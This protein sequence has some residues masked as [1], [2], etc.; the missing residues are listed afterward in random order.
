[1]KTSSPYF[2]VKDSTGTDQLPL[3]ATSAEVNISGVI[4][5]VRVK[6]TYCNEGTSV[7]EAIYVFPASTRAAVNYMQMTL[8]NRILIARIEE[9]QKARQEYEEAKEEGKTAT[10]LEQ[11]RPNVFQMNVANILPGRYHCGRN[12]L[13]RTD[14]PC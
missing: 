13:Y 8:G 6:Q 3:K 4:A 5:D 1:M 11:D 7:I 12:A 2:F 9:K 10:L 14:D